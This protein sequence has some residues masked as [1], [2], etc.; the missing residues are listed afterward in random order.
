MTRRN[1]HPDYTVCKLLTHVP[2][3][4]HQLH[5][6]PFA[7]VCLLFFKLFLFTWHFFWPGHSTPD[8]HMASSLT[9]FSYLT[10]CHFLRPGSPNPKQCATTPT[11]KPSVS[12][13][14]LTLLCSSSLNHH[15]LILFHVF[16]CF[17][18]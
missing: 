10:R 13:Q 1:F 6:P 3:H 2:Q 8:I 17:T 7:L 15:Y 11:P 16:S 9:S 14:F 12:I 18:V 4:M 5:A